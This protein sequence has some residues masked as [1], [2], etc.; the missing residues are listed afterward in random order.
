MALPDRPRMTGTSWLMV[1]LVRR[2][3]TGTCWLMA[4]LVRRLTTGICW[5]MVLLVRRLTTVRSSANSFRKPGL[6]LVS[7]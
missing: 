4:L 6:R 1:L 5:L 2:L 3:T 7:T